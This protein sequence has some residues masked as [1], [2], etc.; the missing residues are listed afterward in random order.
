MRNGRD[1]GR[2]AANDWDNNR[3]TAIIKAREKQEWHAKL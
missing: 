2:K 3:N 1:N